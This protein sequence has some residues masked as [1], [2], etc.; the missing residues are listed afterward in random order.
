MTHVACST[1][2][3][4]VYIHKREKKRDRDRIQPFT[5]AEQQ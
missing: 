2:V 1:P 5:E 3:S 4:Q